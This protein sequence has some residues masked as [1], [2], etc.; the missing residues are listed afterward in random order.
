MSVDDVR[1][2]IAEAIRALGNATTTV[3]QAASQAVEGYGLATS[4]A[5][6]SAHPE[7]LKAL[8]V[9]SDAQVEGRLII[10]RLASAIDRASEYRETL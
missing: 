10:S 9:L 2:E 4:A 3:E 8:A 7:V 1:A 6:D 5:H